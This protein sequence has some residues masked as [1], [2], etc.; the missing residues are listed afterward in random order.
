VELAIERLALGLERSDLVDRERLQLRIVEHRA[1]RFERA[2]VLVVGAQRGRQRPEVRVLARD[3]AQALG[4]AEHFGAREE[5]LELLV[6]F[7]ELVEFA[8]DRRLHGS[9]IAIARHPG[10]GRDPALAWMGGKLDSGLRRNDD[11][12]SE[13][14]TRARPV[15]Q[16]RF[17]TDARP[18]E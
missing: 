4:I 12:W 15:A 2:A 3:V 13:A 7:G 5:V 1:R 9:I 11:V 18:P 14:T 6:A 17:R 10:E 16:A 8:A